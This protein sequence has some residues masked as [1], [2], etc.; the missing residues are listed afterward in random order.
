M[1][2]PLDSFRCGFQTCL[3]GCC[4]TSL[5]YHSL[6]TLESGIMEASSLGHLLA[7]WPGKADLCRPQFPLIVHM[8]NS[9]LQNQS[10]KSGYCVKSLIRSSRCSIRDN[11][12]L[13]CPP[14]NGLSFPVMVPRTFFRLGVQSL[15]VWLSC[16]EE[17]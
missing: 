6:W 14:D 15:V 9:Y 8:D 16:L 4:A 17:I 7:L 12:A 3:Q 5:G 10:G 13:Q 2:Y 1:L 11:T